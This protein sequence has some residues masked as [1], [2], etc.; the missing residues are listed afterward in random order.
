MFILN[1]NRMRVSFYHKVIPM[2]IILLFIAIGCGCN[3]QITNVDTRILSDF[4]I[5]FNIWNDYMPGSDPPSKLSLC[6]ISLNSR[7]MLPEL[8]VS[9]IIITKKSRISTLFKLSNKIVY[10]ESGE[11]F[12]QLIFIPVS[13]FHLNDYEPYKVKLIF[14]IGDEMKKVVYKSQ[15]VQ[16][17]C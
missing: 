13:P 7:R 12:E 16:V 14:K 4:E 6:N 2:V 3:N 5:D 11:H 17:T 1:R 15:Y 8:E 10:D 9:G